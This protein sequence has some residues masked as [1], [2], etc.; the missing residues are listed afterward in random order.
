MFPFV[1]TE[2][3]PGAPLSAAEV[4]RRAALRS[5]PKNG[6]LIAD[7][8][9]NR[10]ETP[11]YTAGK[12]PKR[13]KKIQRA[14][15]GL[16]AVL[17]TAFLA[18]ACARGPGGAGGSGSSGLPPSSSSA[19]SSGPA[20]S[21]G[22]A[23]PSPS[24]SSGASGA[25]SAAF[26]DPEKD[27][28]YVKAYTLYAG[29]HYDAAVQVCDAA[30]AQNAKCFWAY[31]LKGI[32]LYYANGNS[33]APQCLALIDQSLAIDPQYAYGYFNRALVE[34]GLKKLDASIADFNRVLALKPG[35]TWSY[36]GIATDYA[37]ARSADKA[38]EYLKTA[39]SLDPSGVRAQMKDDLSRH[40]SRLQSDPRFQALLNP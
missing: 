24:S 38:I 32:A 40:F 19:V 4:R 33:M 3:P 39:V 7:A 20:P 2:N 34:K 23:V 6:I 21:S 18:N 17:C 15:F 37:D 27:P 22:T 29:N 5:R 26:P 1:P 8:E 12:R 25:A 9:K 16:L 13:M 11:E 31:N 35:D 10:R 30:I 14:V 36:Y 28:Q